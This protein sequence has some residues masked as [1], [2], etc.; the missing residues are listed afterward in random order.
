MEKEDYLQENNGDEEFKT[1]NKDKADFA[2]KEHILKS[3]ITNSSQCEAQG[4][5]RNK[6][7]DKYVKQ[8]KEQK[9]E[10]AHPQVQMKAENA[11][12]DIKKS[13][14]D[15]IR[16]ARNYEIISRKVESGT[17]RFVCSICGKREKCTSEVKTHLLKQHNYIEPPHQK[18][19]HE[20]NKCEFTSG[21]IIDVVRH[22]ANV[23]HS[24]ELYS[25]CH[26]CEYQS[27]RSFA[28]KE[29]IKFKHLKVPKLK[30][31]QCDFTANRK[32]EIRTHVQTVH[33]GIKAKCSSCSFTNI[34]ISTIY[35]HRQRFHTEK[36]CNVCHEKFQGK[37]NLIEHKLRQHQGKV[38]DCN[39][40]DYKSTNKLK[41]QKHLKYAHPLKCS[42][43]QYETTGMCDL[44][45]H[46][47]KVHKMSH[48]QSRLEIGALSYANEKLVKIEFIGDKKENIEGESD[49][50]V[51]E[52]FG[53]KIKLEKLPIKD[54]EK[55]DIKQKHLGNQG[56]DTDINY[57][58]LSNVKEEQINKIRD[59]KEEETEDSDIEWNWEDT[60]NI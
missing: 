50:G 2:I 42:Q 28:V 59:S 18:I 24:T 21:Q 45:A 49:H 7:E 33:E 56:I 25:R 38:I 27:E 1:I 32:S 19:M 52:F 60:Q 30:C 55:C 26:L 17:H 31:E 3:D 40:C 48:R 35:S 8:E 12:L 46:L 10:M 51:F 41:L 11:L 14:I 15:I 16:A 58:A 57:F 47:V 4:I 53:K 9:I 36:S 23:H 54:P 29:H 5:V 20:C 22:M 43:C 39:K 44:Q 34:T 13:E 6:I 37:I